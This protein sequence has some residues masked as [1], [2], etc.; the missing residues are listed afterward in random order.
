MLKCSESLGMNRA[1]QFGLVIGYF[2]VVGFMI[3][4]FKGDPN[5][6]TKKNVQLQIPEGFPNPNYSFENNTITPE[7][8]VLGRKLFYDPILSKDN[9]I[10]CASCHQQFA[11]FAHIDHKLSHGIDN[12]IGIRNVP[13]LQNLIWKDN[14]MWDG[15]VNHLEIQ[16]VNPIT[17]RD[18]MNESLEN[19]IRKLQKSAEYTTLFK[20]AFNDTLV[21]SERILKSLTQFTG[22]MISGN[23]KYDH[24]KK[25]SLDFN[26]SELRG[27]LLFKEKCSSC[28]TPPLFTDNGFQNNGIQPDSLLND[29]GRGAITHRVKDY[30]LFKVPSLRNCEVTFPYMHD[31]RFRKLQHVLDHYSSAS[32]TSKNKKIQ[33]IGILSSQNKVDLEAFLITLTDKTFLLDRR[34]MLVK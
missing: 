15:G 5:K 2:F 33:K 21:T 20:K 25:G 30:Y 11:A 13:A 16:A 6:I 34:F 1:I 12:R 14:F 24:Y 10:S 26:D 23:S 27:M 18:E 19:V 4:S 29:L 8:F 31:G 32:I 7:G 3:Q 9:T 17:S 22:L 28:H